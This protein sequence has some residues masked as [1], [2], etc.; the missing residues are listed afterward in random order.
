MIGALAARNNLRV[1]NARQPVEQ[2][3]VSEFRQ[4]VRFSHIEIFV[5]FLDIVEI[6]VKPQEW[7]SALSVLIYY[8]ARHRCMIWR[9][10]LCVH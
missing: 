10:N 9:L 6:K 5:Q 8:L 3:P 7:P 4:L 1:K 2:L